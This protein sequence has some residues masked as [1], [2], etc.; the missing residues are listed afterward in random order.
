MSSTGGLSLLA[1]ADS[2]RIFAQ[3]CQKLKDEVDLE[4]DQEAAHLKVRLA[5]AN[6]NIGQPIIAVI[7]SYLSWKATHQLARKMVQAN[8]RLI[9][10]MLVLG[11]KHRGTKVFHWCKCVTRPLPPRPRPI[12]SLPTP[13][14]PKGS[15]EPMPIAS[16]SLPMPSN[17]SP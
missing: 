8:I 14:E 5:T 7:M 10:G 4:M 2:Q 13:A 17:V 11:L 9:D 15:A 3:A 1:L 16:A 12:V 6:H